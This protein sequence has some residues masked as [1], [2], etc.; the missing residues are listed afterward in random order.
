MH[1]EP[2]STVPRVCQLRV[3]SAP[4]SRAALCA[5]PG[6]APAGQG[7]QRPLQPGLRLRRRRSH[8]LTRPVC[9]LGL[10]FR[11]YLDSSYFTKVAYNA[12]EVAVSYAAVDGYDYNLVTAL[13]AN[14]GPLYMVV[15]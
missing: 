8:S 4:L 3:P 1:S 14:P 6:R 11:L 7:W 10:P 15:E 13:V 9:F 2:Q 5:L 12:T